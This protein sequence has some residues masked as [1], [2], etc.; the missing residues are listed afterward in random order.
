ML[1]YCVFY[2]KEIIGR[3][4]RKEK[5]INY[6]MDCKLNGEI[7]NITIKEMSKKEYENYCKKFLEELLK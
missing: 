2:K 1:L 6:F 7:T 5:A 4:R 3:F